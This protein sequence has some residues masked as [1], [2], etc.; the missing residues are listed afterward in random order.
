MRYICFLY[1][2]ILT[3][4]IWVNLNFKFMFQQFCT[5]CVVWKWALHADINYWKSIHIVVPKF[6]L[7][8]IACY[9]WIYRIYY[10]HFTI[11]INILRLSPWLTTNLAKSTH[12]IWFTSLSIWMLI[13]KYCANRIYFAKMILTWIILIFITWFFAWSYSYVVITIRLL[14][15]NWK[16]MRWKSLSIGGGAIYAQRFCIASRNIISGFDHR[17][18]L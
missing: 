13:L 18:K 12:P 8:I 3:A 10:S 4:I 11:D 5:L 16:L 17:T 7:V 2:C 9:L 1:Q 14:L 15:N 6:Y